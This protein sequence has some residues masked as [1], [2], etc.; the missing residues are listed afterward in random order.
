[1][2][3]FKY[4]YK[5]AK[6]GLPDSNGLLSAHVPRM[7]ALAGQPRGIYP[8]ACGISAELAVFDH[9]GKKRGPYNR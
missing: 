4:F 9:E 3:L 7:T 2:L 1:M 5:R 6:D 8:G